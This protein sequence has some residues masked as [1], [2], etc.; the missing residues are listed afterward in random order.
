MTDNENI[1]KLEYPN[2]L[3]KFKLAGKSL[4]NRIIHSAMSTRY[5]QDGLPTKKLIDYQTFSLW[6]LMAI[7]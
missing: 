2:L 7:F 1:N 5:A 4:K 6:D 3:S